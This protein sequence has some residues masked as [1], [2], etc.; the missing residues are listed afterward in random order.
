MDFDHRDPATKLFNLTT[1]RVMLMATA[2]VLAE[3]AKCDVV[4]ANCHRV[5]TQ[6]SWIGRPRKGDYKA[7]SAARRAAL[8]KVRADLLAEL[9]NVPCADCGCRFPKAAMD[10]DHRDPSDKSYTVSRML[11]RTSTEEVLREAAK[12]DVVCANCHRMRTY[13]RRARAA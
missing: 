8:W 11:F 2:K 13:Q 10:F 12:C 9:R 6:A 1:G 3:A 4:C 5:R 7:P